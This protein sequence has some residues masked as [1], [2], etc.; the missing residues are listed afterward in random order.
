MENDDHRNEYVM[1]EKGRIWTGRQCGRPWDFG[2][3]I[4]QYCF[5]T[6]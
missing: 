5:P 3:V 4:L 1:N 6:L 2:Q